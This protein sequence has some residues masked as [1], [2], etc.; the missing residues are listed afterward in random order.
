MLTLHGKLE[1][2][3]L[4]PGSTNRKTGE[5]YHPRSVVQLKVQD[6]RG[7]TQLVTLTVPD[8]RPYEN[9]AGQEVAFPVRAYAPGATV[10]F[11]LADEVA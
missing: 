10:Q 11:A 3:L 1:S 5:I 7:L 9:K 2:A 6:R 8:H 4:I